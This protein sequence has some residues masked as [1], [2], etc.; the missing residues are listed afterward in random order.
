MPKTLIIQNARIH[1]IEKSTLRSLYDQR[2]TL[3]TFRDFNYVSYLGDLV[4]IGW[5]NKEKESRAAQEL[6]IYI[7]WTEDNRQLNASI[8]SLLKGIVETWDIYLPKEKRELYGNAFAD[9]EFTP[10]SK[11]NINAAL[12]KD[13]DITYYFVDV[14]YEIPS[15]KET[16][17]ELTD[18]ER[19]LGVEFKESDVANAEVIDDVPI[20]DMCEMYAGIRGDKLVQIVFHN[21]E[22]MC[23]EY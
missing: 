1:K 12:V 8:C 23:P 18:L 16:L 22:E 13:R 17:N 6:H 2:E 11:I 19:K 9:L 5:R 7:L 14:V 4:A 21:D 20:D 15:V 10:L 3:D